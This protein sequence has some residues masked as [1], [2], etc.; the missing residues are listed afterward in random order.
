MEKTEIKKE[1]KRKI[2]TEEKGLILGIAVLSLAV[3]VLLIYVYYSPKSTT[4]QYSIEAIEIV[5][6]CKDCFDVKLLADSIIKDNNLNVKSRETLDYTSQKA[7]ELISRYNLKTIPALIIFSKNINEIKINNGVFS[8]KDDYAIFDKSVPYLN[9]ETKEIKG[10]VKLTEI[11]PDKCAECISLSQIKNQFEKNGV[12]I[13]KYEA[14]NSSSDSGKKLINENELNFV[15]ILLI[16]KDIKEYWW[17][18]DQIKDSLVE[19]EDYYILK[20]AIPPYLDLKDRRVKGKVD[21]L[22]LENKSCE[23]CFNV[24]QLKSS[25]QG[26]GVYFVSEKY[27]DVSSTEGKSLLNN[28]NITAIPTIVLSRDIQDYSSL[29]NM[30]EQAGSFENDG[31]FVFRKLETLNAEYQKV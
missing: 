13:E 4:K 21:I 15:P 8:I 9:L 14:I 19:K 30:L 3:I 10:F 12:K 28:Y 17:I 16:S 6:D 11:K 23:N 20:N 26:L 29:K 25:F 7:K 22:Y 5:G 1:T 24:T 31:K 27:V 18:F 2:W